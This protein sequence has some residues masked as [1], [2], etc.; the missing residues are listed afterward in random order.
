ML[1][2]GVC[3][4][5]IYAAWVIWLLSVCHF[6][7]RFFVIC[8][9]V[10]TRFYGFFIRLGRMLSDKSS[11]DPGLCQRLQCYS[12]FVKRC[13]TLKSFVR[14]LGPKIPNVDLAAERILYYVFCTSKIPV[15]I[16][17]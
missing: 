17:L 9:V 14:F 2:N 5:R 15:V 1:V 12:T 4:Y 7:T 16:E 8:T 6:S 10:P 11:L 3:L 13:C